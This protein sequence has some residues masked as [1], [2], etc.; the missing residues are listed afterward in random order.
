MKVI[1]G[2]ST[3]LHISCRRTKESCVKYLVEAG[4][5]AF[6]EDSKGLNPVDVIGMN[7]KEDPNNPNSSDSTEGSSVGIAK[8]LLAHQKPDVMPRSIAPDNKT[9]W[10]RIK[11]LFSVDDH[12]VRPITALHTA[13]SEN[14]LNLIT[15]LL[16]EGADVLVWNEMEETPLH[17][18][19]KKKF[20]DALCLMLYHGDN[21][22]RRVVNAVD[23]RRRT[24]LHLAVSE[25]WTDGISTLLEEGADVTCKD[26]K[27]QTV[28]HI[29]AK[30]GNF[31]ILTELLTVPESLQVCFFNF[32]YQSN[33]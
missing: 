9:G 26:N 7:A 12:D 16:D 10:L 27:Q 6:E 2:G 1:S 11:R 15:I 4:A 29:A 18:A 30:I 25:E 13:V 33:Y 3:P 17:L 8:L 20:S 31:K 24:L 19:V 21:R 14:N 5:N 22:E 32:H 28:L 23:A